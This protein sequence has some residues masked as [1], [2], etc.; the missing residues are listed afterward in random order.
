MLLKVGRP[1]GEVE[2]AVAETSEREAERMYSNV[3]WLTLM[4]AV[5]PLYGLT[6]TVWGMII[7]FRQT[8]ILQ[9]GQNKAD[10]LAEGIYTALVTTLGGL[11]IAI[12]AAIV[13]HWFEG[14]IQS[15]FHH[16]DDLLFNLLPQVERYE[17]R[18]RF[19]R[20]VGDDAATTSS[21]LAPPPPPPPEEAPPVEAEAVAATRK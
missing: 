19:G 2:H 17:G 9:A 3:R 21:S 18:V 14:R 5:A 1:H 8:T 10:F 20:Q 6:G 16:I 7:A 12:P 11:L 4:A 15:L 13:A